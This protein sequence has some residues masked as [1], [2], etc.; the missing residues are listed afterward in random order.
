MRARA[1][2]NHTTDASHISLEHTQIPLVQNEYLN[3]TE[4]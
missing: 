1:K 4:V 3:T 2:E